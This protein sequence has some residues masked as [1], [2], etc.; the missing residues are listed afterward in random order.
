VN[1]RFRVPLM[2]QKS[3]RRLTAVFKMYVLSTRLPI[4]EVTSLIDGHTS[5]EMF[6]AFLSSNRSDA[7]SRTQVMQPTS[8]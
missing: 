2:S 3:K 1:L 4:I 8:Y 7:G 5:T 6:T